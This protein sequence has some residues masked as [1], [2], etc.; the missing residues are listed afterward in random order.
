MDLRLELLETFTAV[1]SDGSRHTVRAYDRLTPDPSLG[2]DR[3]VSTGTLEFR[4]DDGRIL[5]VH[6]DG[7]AHA[8]GSDVLLTL[9]AR[10]APADHA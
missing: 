1:G 2:G 10:A 7:T 9:P 5:T 3:W 6:S 4:L 8:A